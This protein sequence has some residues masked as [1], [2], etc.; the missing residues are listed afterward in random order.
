MRELRNTKIIA[1]DHG[2]GNMKTANTV[3]PTGIK[4]Y[5]TEPIFTGNILEYNGIYYRIG[6]GHK[7]F[8]PDKAMNEEYYLLTLMAI[9]RE[10]NVFS[11]READVHPVSYTHLRH[12]FLCGIAGI[13]KSELAKAYAKRYIKPVSYTHLD[14]YKRQIQK[15]LSILPNAA[16]AAIVSTPNPF[17]AACTI[18]FEILYMLDSI[19]VGSPI[20]S[21]SMALS[22]SGSSPSLNWMSST[23]PMTWITLPMCFSDIGYNS[24]S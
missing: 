3:T 13:G 23:G 20:L 16:H 17:N 14:V 19:P 6:E 8:I 21:I 24:F 22:R 1:V 18:T 2:Y 9:A 15:R 11:I 7:E 10:L 4:A 12:V 5:E